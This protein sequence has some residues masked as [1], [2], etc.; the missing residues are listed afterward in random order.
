MGRGQTTTHRLCDFQTN[1]A[2]RAEL[3]KKKKRNNQTNSMFEKQGKNTHKLF[4][5]SNGVKVFCA[6]IC[7]TF[8]KCTNG[9]STNSVTVKFNTLSL[10]PFKCSHTKLVKLESQDFYRFIFPTS[11]RTVFTYKVKIRHNLSLKPLKCC[12]YYPCW[13]YCNPDLCNF[14]SFCKDHKSI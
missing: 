3:M 13:L 11:F 8:C 2:Q 9:C 4:S 14:C 7:A 6:V 12:F 5:K 10:K 1:L